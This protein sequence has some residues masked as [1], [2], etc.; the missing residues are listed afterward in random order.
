MFFKVGRNESWVTLVL[1]DRM[2]W[3]AL[4]LASSLKRCYT[5]RKLSVLVDERK[6]SDA[7]K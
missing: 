1:D 5:Q 3:E 6:I 2:G 4:V 7:M